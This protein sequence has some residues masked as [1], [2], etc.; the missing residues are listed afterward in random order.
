MY[1]AYNL[2]RFRL[3]RLPFPGRRHVS[4]AGSGDQGRGKGRAV[5]GSSAGRPHEPGHLGQR[6]M[7]GPRARR[8][9]QITARLKGSCRRVTPCDL[10]PWRDAPPTC[11][12]RREWER[13]R[14]PC[15]TLSAVTSDSA[16]LC[17]LCPGVDTRVPRSRPCGLRR[18]RGPS[19]LDRRP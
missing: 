5:S 16:S 10:R 8:R 1:P 6:W 19:A 15:H 9:P 18:P 2:R 17:R 14:R 13:P 3:P 7:D 12:G 11:L 4:A